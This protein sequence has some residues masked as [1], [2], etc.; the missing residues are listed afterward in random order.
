MIIPF[1]KLDAVPDLGC[2]M[3]CEFLIH[4]RHI[5]FDVFQMIAEEAENVVH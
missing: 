2:L 5:P 4:P 1:Q 3:R